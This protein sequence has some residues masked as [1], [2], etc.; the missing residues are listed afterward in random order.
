MTAVCVRMP[1][2]YTL[3]IPDFAPGE[4]SLITKEKI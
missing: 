1:N 4:K 3:G 2:S